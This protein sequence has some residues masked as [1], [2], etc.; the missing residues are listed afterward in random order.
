M[1]IEPGSAV[2]SSIVT[3]PLTKMGCGTLVAPDVLVGLVVGSDEGVAGPVVPPTPPLL[4][5]AP[6]VPP[7]G[8]APPLLWPMTAAG[9]DRPTAIAAVIDRKSTRLNS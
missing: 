8:A 9:I 5:V 4:P 2:P 1:V 7:A 3:R 6:P